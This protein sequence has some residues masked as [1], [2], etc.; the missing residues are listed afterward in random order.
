MFDNLKGSV[1]IRVDLWERSSLVK[2]VRVK[3]AP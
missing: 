1:M 2:I 3:H